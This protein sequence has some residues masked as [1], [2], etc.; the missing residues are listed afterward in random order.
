[1]DEKKREGAT[2]K[3][4][5]VVPTFNRAEILSEA[6]QSVFAQTHR[7]L[8]LLVVDD[9]ST[10]ETENVV[11]S[12]GARHHCADFTVHYLRQEHR[13]GNEARNRGIAEV[14]GAYIAFLDS[15]DR[16]DP[17]KLH[18]QLDVFRRDGEIAGV[19]CGVRHVDRESGRVMEPTGRTY[20]QGR[21]LDR[22]LV[23]DVTAP[24]SAWVVRRDVFTVAGTFDTELS[25]RQDWD[26]WIRLAE[27]Y[28]I[29]CVPET[30]V[31]YREHRGARTASDPTKEIHA[32]R[33]IHGKYA[34]LRH[35]RPWSVQRAT[36]AAY[37]RRMVRVHFHHQLGWALALHYQ[38]SS[39]A[40]WPF[41]FDSYA[42]LAGMF[43]PRGLRRRAHRAWN[44]VLGRT[45]LAIRSH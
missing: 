14:R 26:M 17:M 1:M 36:R 13:G 33:R 6:L 24:T 45:C 15:D 8:E 39:I 10:D 35:G 38:L 30:L 43:L 31:E 29:G 5:V 34:Y 28:L 21:I 40:S 3:I 12:W 25:A 23:H 18:K 37:F 22:L 16:W 19:Y 44:R 4:S 32:L 7:P 42:A 2:I 11:A 41:V 9:G 20:A 27:H